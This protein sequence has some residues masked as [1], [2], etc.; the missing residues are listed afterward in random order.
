MVHLPKQV[1][2]ADGVD[3]APQRV[4]VHLHRRP[5]MQVQ[6]LGWSTR[7]HRAKP[8]RRHM[9]VQHLGFPCRAAHGR[10]PS[11]ATAGGAGRDIGFLSRALGFLAFVEEQ[12][13]GMHA[14]LALLRRHVD[15]QPLRA[16][17]RRARNEMQDLGHAAQLSAIKLE[18]ASLS[19]PM[20]AER[21]G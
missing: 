17:E 14:E 3:I 10:D 15:R 6:D 16:A 20:L 4:L 12:Y 5:H 18:E 8:R 9:Q 7:Q 13:A 19:M 21:G 2:L 1:A 11:A